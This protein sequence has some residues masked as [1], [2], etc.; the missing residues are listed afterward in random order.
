[1]ISVIVPVYN[2]SEF[3]EPFLERLAELNGDAEFIFVDD[4]SDDSTCASIQNYE[5]RLSGMQLLT[6]NS[7]K[8]MAPGNNAGAKTATGDVL[9][10]LPADCLP[11]PNALELI[12]Q[13]LHNTT[14]IGGAYFKHYTSGSLFMKCGEFY[15]NNLRFQRAGNVVSTNGIFLRRETFDKLGGF[16]EHGF[17]D[18]VL[19]SDRLKKIGRLAVIKQPLIVSSRRYERDGISKRIINNLLIVLLYRLGRSPEQL[20]NLYSKK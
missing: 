14:A 11:P 12:E 19:L 18:D 13:T 1:M 3:I 20:K 4:S 5:A 8:G 7:H 9:W 6:I 17:L 15:L 2:E 16:T 10:F